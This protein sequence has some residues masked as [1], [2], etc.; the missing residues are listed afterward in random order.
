MNA[1]VESRGR[2]EV[3]GERRVSQE[4]SALDRSR[5]SIDNCVAFESPAPSE[6]GNVLDCRILRNDDE[7]DDDGEALDGWRNREG[8]GDEAGG[9]FTGGFDGDAVKVFTDA[10]DGDTGGAD[11]K[12]VGSG[13]T[14]DRRFTNG[15]PLAAPW[16]RPPRDLL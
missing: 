1:H 2:R 11:S 10:F 16:P 4:C 3:Y 14:F 8:A 13:T 15:R 12:I 7:V 9:A 6:W 5:S